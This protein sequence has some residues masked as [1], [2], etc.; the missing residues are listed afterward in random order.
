MSVVRAGLDGMRDE[1]SSVPLTRRPTFIKT[2][3]KTRF[4]VQRQKTSTWSYRDVPTG[5]P[6][7]EV[8]VHSPIHVPVRVDVQSA[9][10]WSETETEHV[11]FDP[12]SPNVSPL[13]ELSLKTL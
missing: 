6:G 5:P 12:T 10:A 7:A 11:T 4:I 9:C 1:S 2:I 3:I 13:N 8:G